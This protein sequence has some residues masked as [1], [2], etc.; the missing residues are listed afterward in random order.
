MFALDPRFEVWY[1]DADGEY[2]GAYHQQFTDIVVAERFAASERAVLR[3]PNIRV[4]TQ[5]AVEAV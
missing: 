1:F 5:E 4:V 3:N 2:V